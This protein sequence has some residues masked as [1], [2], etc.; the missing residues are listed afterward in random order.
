M[1]IE[2]LPIGSVIR[3]KRVISLLE[4]QIPA[5][6]EIG[7]RKIDSGG[8]HV[9]NYRLY[10][11]MNEGKDWDEERLIISRIRSSDGRIREYAIRGTIYI[12]Q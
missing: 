1:R 3:N 7:I 6:I 12:S 2:V 11:R 4:S 10:T 8:Q 5:G 9:E